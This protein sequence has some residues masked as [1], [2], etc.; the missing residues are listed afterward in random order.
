[1]QKVLETISRFKRKYKFI[2]NKNVI[3]S[4]IQEKRYDL[5][6][7]KIVKKPEFFY[8]LSLLYRLQDKYDKE[9]ELIEEALKFNINKE[10]FSERKSWHEL[11]M[12]ERCEFRPPLHLPIA[13]DQ[14]PAK[15]TLEQLCFV[16]AGDSLYFNLLVELLESLKATRLYKNQ[17]INLIDCG[18]SETEKKYLK[19]HFMVKEIKDPGWDI[20]LQEEFPNGFK[21]MVA[22]AFLP[23]HFPGYQYYFWIDADSWIQ[24]ERALVNFITNAERVGLGISCSS[25]AS[26]GKSFF[27]QITHRGTLKYI[28]PEYQMIDLFKSSGGVSVGAFCIK[29]ESTVQSLWSKIIT[30]NTLSKGFYRMADTDSCTIAA[31]LENIP[32]L[33]YD[34]HCHGGFQI[35][36][37]VFIRK[38]LIVGIVALPAKKKWIRYRRIPECTFTE[39]G[40]AILNQ[41]D[42]AAREKFFSIK[43]HLYSYKTFPW[44]DKPHIEKLL[45]E[46]INKM[47]IY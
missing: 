10:Y 40:A 16:S 26:R 6:E 28:D 47:R 12:E 38:D 14:V 25:P 23:K 32:I 30:K 1:M 31:L 17:P 42:P 24:D 39:K 13:P 15:A 18:F 27:T 3:L 9:K 45:C 33:S 19:S 35:D 4:H 34:H 22:R 8:I 36:N 5:A 21:A 7:K 37:G 46:S 20:P 41:M 43:R 11:P 29:S 2:V 44:K